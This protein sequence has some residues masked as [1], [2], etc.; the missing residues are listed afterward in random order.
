MN[1]LPLLTSQLP[2]NK[3]QGGYKLLELGVTLRSIS[4]A[5]CSLLIKLCRLR[6]TYPEDDA[7]LV[8]EARQAAVQ[9]STGAEASASQEAD[10]AEGDQTEAAEDSP[11]GSL[12]DDSE[13]EDE[14]EEMSDLDAQAQVPDS[15]LQQDRD[16][17]VHDTEE[18][19][20]EAELQEDI[21]DTLSN[22]DD[23]EE[24]SEEE[25]EEDGSQDVAVEDALQVYDELGGAVRE[26]ADPDGD[27]GVFTEAGLVPVQGLKEAYNP[28]KDG[29]RAVLFTEEPLD[30]DNLSGV[31][32]NE[33]LVSLEAE[34]ANQTG[35][36]GQ[37][38][39]GEEF[40]ATSSEATGD[41]PES[42]EDATGSS[43]DAAKAGFFEEMEDQTN[44]V[45]EIEPLQ[46]VD[47]EYPEG[48]EPP[49]PDEE[50]VPYHPGAP[51]GKIQ[52]VAKIT[53]TM[54]Y[55][56]QEGWYMDLDTYEDVLRLLCEDPEQAILA[57]EIL[58]ADLMVSCLLSN[59]RNDVP[60]LRRWRRI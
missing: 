21:G 25:E 19:E 51:D 48:Q 55:G 49:P 23:E 35:V 27:Y 15:T 28:L 32:I 29:Y 4:S 22:E 20:E 18:Q 44:S 39:E 52:L 38:P 46:I 43:T 13:E 14:E 26:G 45:I 47:V 17:I 56:R 41:A 60:M 50:V 57:Q 2:A 31:E 5:R 33:A 54:E 58:S 42:A 12:D 40:P 16:Q 34:L 59:S 11:A 9:E 53:E 1:Q 30:L 7:L 37:S 8:E 3:R 24:E 10:N 6:T 36:A